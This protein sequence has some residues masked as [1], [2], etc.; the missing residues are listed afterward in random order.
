MQALSQWSQIVKLDTKY[1]IPGSNLHKS[2][3]VLAARGFLRNLGGGAA[4]GSRADAAGDRCATR[5]PAGAVTGSRVADDGRVV[6]SGAARV[7]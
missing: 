2:R 4:A 3:W 5:A 6:Q 1:S 7:R